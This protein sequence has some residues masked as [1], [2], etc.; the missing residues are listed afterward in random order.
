MELEAFFEEGSGVREEAGKT[1]NSRRCLKKAAE[2]WCSRQV[3][4]EKIVN[5]GRLGGVV[6]VPEPASMVS[7]T[8]SVAV[9]VHLARDLLSGLLVVNRRRLEWLAGRRSSEV[10]VVCWSSIGGG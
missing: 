4:G 9:L 3:V 1:R 8:V 10:G 5:F 6:V 7:A 2:R